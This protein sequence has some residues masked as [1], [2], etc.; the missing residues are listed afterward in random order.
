MPEAGKQTSMKNNP[1]LPKLHAVI[2]DMDGVLIDSEKCWKR[3]ELVFLAR[4]IHD[5]DRFDT[6]RFIGL[7]MRDVYSLL[8]REHL[9]KVSEDEF[10]QVYHDAAAVI[11]KDWTCLMPGVLDFIG[12]ARKK[13]LKIGL[14]SSSPLS[15]IEMVLERFE[16]RTRFD[17]IV[18]SDHVGGEAKPSPRVYQHA[19]SLLGVNSSKSLAIEDS[20]YG[21]ISAKKAGLHCL[22][23]RNGGNDHE[24]FSLADG[25]IDS[26]ENY[27]I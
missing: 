8:V 7:G 5:P 21:I 18:S 3:A 1:V 4:L 11:Y 2:L 22:G 23:F 16:L 14:A 19:L 26:F 20:C 24:D 10:R 6:N 9:I 12:S 13:G 15:W 27:E 17:Q 25:E